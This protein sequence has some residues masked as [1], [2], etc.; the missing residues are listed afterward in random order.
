MIIPII[1]FALLYIA[2]KKRFFDF[3]SI[4]MISTIIYFSPSIFGYVWY[5]V[6]V[7][8]GGYEDIFININ[9]MV[10]L[11]H[12]IVLSILLLSMIIFDI[13]NKK[14]NNHIKI[15]EKKYITTIFVLFTLM[16]YSNFLINNLNFALNGDKNQFD[17]W[18]SMVA[19]S[20][21]FCMALCVTERRYVYLL[22][23]SLVVIF[24]MYTGNREAIVFS[25]IS[26]LSVML[27]RRGKGRL[28]WY[29]K[30]IIFGFILVISALAYKNISAA[31]LHGDWEI[32][33]SRLGNL[34]YYGD[35]LSKS[36]PFVTQTI[37]HYAISL[38]WSYDG[39]FVKPLFASLVPLGDIVFG[40]V[41]TISGYINGSLF[42]DVGYGVASN[43]WAEAYIYGGW[44]ILI[45][46]AIIYS[47]IPALLNKIM[48][49]T[50]YYYQSV[51]I[52]VFGAIFLFY[53]HRSGLDS[54]INMAKR[55][56]IFYLVCSFISLLIDALA[57]SL[58]GSVRYDPMPR[59]NGIG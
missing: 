32:A 58:K 45:V 36:E 51:L 5:R 11:A 31:I 4:S 14:I 18:Y 21:P 26:I 47:M 25:A 49:S 27:W 48:E 20:I 3:Y 24:E 41:E 37:L 55:L 28:I 19:I 59:H 15:G 23:L 53:I 43:V 1:A 39:S 13:F 54:A 33:L 16:I 35:T 2:L 52:S 46:Y 17:R 12:I 34:E 22:I 57:A 6:P 7:K 38:G 44:P 50:K 9:P 56:S 40:N 29:Y 30:Y 10:E 8:R 42:E